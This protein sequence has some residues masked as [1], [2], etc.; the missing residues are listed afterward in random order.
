M[1]ALN[2]IKV[3]FDVINAEDNLK[4]NTLSFLQGE[5][6]KREQKSRYVLKYA[7]VFAVLLIVISG[8]GG[9]EMLHRAVSYISIDI[10]PSIELGLN[11]FEYVV[12]ASAYNEDGNEILK[13]VDL[14]GKSYTDAINDLLEQQEFI[15]YFEGNNRIDFT[16]VSE[17]QDEIMQG[18]QS[19]SGY[20]Q[21]NGYC[22]SADSELAEQAHEHGFSIGK[23]RAYMKLHGYDNTITEDEC[24]DMTMKQIHD[25]IEEH[26]ISTGMQGTHHNDDMDY[27]GRGGRHHRR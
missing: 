13:K 10:N 23:Y 27:H 16:V 19:C 8:I 4:K 17:K 11:R 22:H 26:S 9:Y 3:M 21:H 7:M 15:G 6:I 1:K 2:R 14:T 20:M 25:M 18:I 24:R 5:R 12:E